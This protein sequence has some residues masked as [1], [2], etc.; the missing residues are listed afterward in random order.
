MNDILISNVTFFQ[1]AHIQSACL[2][3]KKMCLN[4]QVN[5]DCLLILF[6]LKQFDWTER[7]YNSSEVA[8]GRFIILML[9]R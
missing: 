5:S 6:S 9:R 3:T 2:K 7:Y 4:F 1:F 8:E